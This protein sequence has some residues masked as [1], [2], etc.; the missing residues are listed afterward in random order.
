MKR[1][2][3]KM[4]LYGLRRGGSASAA[5]SLSQDRRARPRSMTP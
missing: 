2:N 1:D 5:A 3:D 4:T